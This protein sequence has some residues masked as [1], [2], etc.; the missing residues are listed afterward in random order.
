MQ[1]GIGLQGGSGGLNR[2][3]AAGTVHPAAFG[4]CP[5]PAGIPSGPT[6]AGVKTSD[7]LTVL[8]MLLG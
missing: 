3:N 6:G 8:G 2:P 4:R 7:L 5:H 1:D